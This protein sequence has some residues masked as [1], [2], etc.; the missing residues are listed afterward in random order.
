MKFEMKFEFVELL[1]TIL[2]S[3]MFRSCVFCIF[4]H[5]SEGEDFQCIKV[6]NPAF[7]RKI[8][9]HESKT[10]VK[11]PSLIVFDHFMGLVLKG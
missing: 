3:I 6:C 1:T 8:L 11:I 4:S 10:E 5:P 7:S 9:L 2:F